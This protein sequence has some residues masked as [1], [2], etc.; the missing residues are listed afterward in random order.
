MDGRC[1][2][3]MSEEKKVYIILV[4]LNQWLDTIE[5]MESLF[6]NKYSNYQIVVVDNNSSNNSIHHF[7]NWAEG[8]ESAPY[9]TPQPLTHL[10]L[11]AEKK[12]IPYIVYEEEQALT[13]GDRRKES[14][15]KNKNGAAIQH[16]LIFIQCRKNRGFAAG[17]NTGIKYT[18]E[19][20]D[21]D[22]VWLLNND[23]VTDENVLTALVSKMEQSEKQNQKLGLVGSKVLFYEKSG[24]LQA[25]GGMY[26]LKT[27]LFYHL[28]TGE[29]DHGQF[30]REDAA[31]DYPMGCSMLCSK[32]FIED[33]GL[34][35]EK[36][37]MYY[38]ELD[39]SVRARKKGWNITYASQSRVFH[40]QGATTGE[41][42]LVKH[43]PLPVACF[44]Y[45]NM[46]IF[47]RKFYPLLLPVAYLRLVFKVIKN[48]FTGNRKES[49]LITGIILGKRNCGNHLKHNANIH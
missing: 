6:K 48:F 40:K 5:C 24:V 39:W 21:M 14:T 3:T 38:E 45:R 36:Y 44:Q 31:I 16:P 13:G 33:V 29:T 8:K 34:L 32:S 26:N 22:Y 47:Y 23:T 27:T 35:E 11:P 42:M 20:G 46:L 19:K 18:L 9:S 41:K 2:I 15:L 49:L 7:Q 10:T 1:P 17:C 28:G 25:V 30:D 37:F 12:P 4:N 43:L